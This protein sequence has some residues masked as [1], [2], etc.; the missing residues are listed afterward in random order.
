MPCVCSECVFTIQEAESVLDAALHPHRPVDS[1]AIP[2]VPAHRP[3]APK[4]PGVKSPGKSRRDGEEFVAS[5]PTDDGPGADT[6]VA[7]AK[8]VLESPSELLVHLH[9]EDIGKLEPLLDRCKEVGG[10]LRLIYTTDTVLARLRAG[11]ALQ[12]AVSALEAKRCVHLPRSVWHVC[13]FQHLCRGG[14]AVDSSC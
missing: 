8:F 9:A 7:A 5:S 14:Q 4:S 6:A 2:P 3:T 1:H 10:D 13:G 11:V 12:E